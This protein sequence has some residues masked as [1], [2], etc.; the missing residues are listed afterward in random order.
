MAY[1]RNKLEK[2][3]LKRVRL[4][5]SIFIPGE[6]FLEFLA[7]A[8]EL[9]TARTLVTGNSD[10]NFLNSVELPT[11]V[12]LWLC[13]NNGIPQEKK[14]RTLPIGIENLRLGRAGLKKYFQAHR[15]SAP[16]DRVLV[17]PMS[18]TNPARYMVVFEALK[19]PDI[20]E[21]RQKLIDESE[22]FSLTRDFRFVMCCEGNGFENHRIWETLYQGSFPI[23]INSTWSKSLQYLGLPIM[24]VDSLDEIQADALQDFATRNS[25]FLPESAECLWTPFWEKVIRRGF[26]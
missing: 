14:I 23:L 10:Q 25:D 2:L 16:I 13:Q 15:E 19:R 5:D 9:I 24:Y 20:F 3:D 21:V 7:D 6:R 18:P 26:V 1:G 11:S 8:S 22:Y 12:N 17:P 4:S